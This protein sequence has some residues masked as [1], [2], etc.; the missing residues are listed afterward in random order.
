MRSGGALQFLVV[1]PAMPHN[2]GHPSLVSEWKLSYLPSSD[3]PSKNIIFFVLLQAAS[4]LPLFSTSYGK[5]AQ[6]RAGPIP[7]NL[8]ADANEEKRREPQDDAHTAFADDRG[9]PIGKTVAKKNAQRHERRSNDRRKNG[10][11]VRA[12]MMRLVGAKRDGHGYGAW[13]NRKGESER[14]EGAAKNIGGIHFSLHLW[15]AVHFLFAFQHSPAIGNDDQAATDLHD[16]NGNPKEMQNV[17][18]DEKRSN[19][20]DEAVHCDL[21]SENPARRS[22]IFARQ[23]EK[24][25]AA[26]NRIHDGEQRS[27][28]QQDTFGGFQQGV[29]SIGT[30]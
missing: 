12:E 15:A 5:G 21:A 4:L 16:G 14:V 29:S 3:Q 28:D 6:Q 24:D 18:A 1:N 8:D 17:R 11:D 25:G 9:K 19:Q 30:V 20:K 10:E 26:A 22:G 2:S 23:G 13:S 7:K 27:E